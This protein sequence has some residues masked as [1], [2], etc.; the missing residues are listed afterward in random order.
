[1]AAKEQELRRKQMVDQQRLTQVR[2]NLEG[3]SASDSFGGGYAS[4]G[5]KTVVGAANSLEDMIKSAECEL[6]RHKSKHERKILELKKGYSDDPYSRQR[7]LQELESLK[8]ENDPEYIRKEKALQDAL[9]YFKEMQR[10]EIM[11]KAG[12][13]LDVDLLGG[14]A[15]P[16]SGGTDVFGGAGLTSDMGGGTADLL[17]F[18]GGEFSAQSAPTSSLLHDGARD[19]SGLQPMDI[20]NEQPISEERKGKFGDL[21]EQYA[22]NEQTFKVKL[23][24]APCAEPC[25]WITSMVCYP[26]AQYKL[27]Y[28]A[29]NHVEPGSG[30]NNYKCC[31]GMFGGCFCI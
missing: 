20:S 12:G 3:K 15:A 4:T 28:K 11:T 25:C 19:D 1:M 29:L 22:D 16:S 5:G 30:W 9:E 23:C 2:S 18:D 10:K 13:V 21:W 31:Q 27:R 24:S 17:G 14:D 26:C 8:V 6:K 7:Q